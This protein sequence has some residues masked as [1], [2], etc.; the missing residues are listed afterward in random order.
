MRVV[1]FIDFVRYLLN[2]QEKNPAENVVLAPSIREESEK[3]KEKLCSKEQSRIKLRTG[4]F[5]YASTSP[6]ST[7]LQIQE[8]TLRYSASLGLKNFQTILDSGR[9]W[10]MMNHTRPNLTMPYPRQARSAS[11]RWAEISTQP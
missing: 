9:L 10:C 4:T 8:T 7:R 6:C 11:Y 1:I 3:T 5:D 2:L